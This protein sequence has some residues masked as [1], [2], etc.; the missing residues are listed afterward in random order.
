MYVWLYA[1][2]TSMID[3]IPSIISIPF[4][5]QGIQ[6]GGSNLSIMGRSV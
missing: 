2:P 6:P 4:A 3:K 1:A 5:G